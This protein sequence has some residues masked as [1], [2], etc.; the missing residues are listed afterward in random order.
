MYDYSKID[1]YLAFINDEKI[2]EYELVADPLLGYLKH[3]RRPWAYRFLMDKCSQESRVLEIGAGSPLILRALRREIGCEC[4]VLDPMEGKGNGPT[5]FK[6]IAGNNSDMTFIANEIGDFSPSLPDNYFDFVFSV[7]VLE[8]IPLHEFDKCFDDMIRVTKPGGVI[9]H[10]VDL[11]IDGQPNRSIF[12]YLLSVSEKKGLR[13][14]TPGS[15][16]DFEGCQKDPNLFFLSP[17]VWNI[18]RKGAPKAPFFKKF[19]RMISFNVG[20]TK[21]DCLSL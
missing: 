19:K 16:F 18:W 2:W 11:C 3:Y 21:P 15:P 14:F 4:W 10:L 7:S 6:K 9:V 13:E 20:Y 5:N 17:T 8:H 1:E 12:D